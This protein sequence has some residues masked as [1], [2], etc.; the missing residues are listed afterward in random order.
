M[1]G[2]EMSPS[3]GAEE[4]AEA[5]DAVYGL[6]EQTCA[7]RSC[8]REDVTLDRNS[9]TFYCRYHMKHAEGRRCSS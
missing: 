8:D 4:T 5:M 7:A 2:V 1:S 9:G 3:V 6:G